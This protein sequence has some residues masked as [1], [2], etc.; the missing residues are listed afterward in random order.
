MNR[1]EALGG[2]HMWFVKNAKAS[3][4]QN[5]NWKEKATKYDLS[6]FVDQLQSPKTQRSVLLQITRRFLCCVQV[7]SDDQG[8]FRQQTDHLIEAIV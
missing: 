6:I 8:S 3:V 4:C 2:N 5:L 7:L 1:T